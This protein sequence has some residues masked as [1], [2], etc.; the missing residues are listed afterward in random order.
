MARPPER[1]ARIARVRGV[2][3]VSSSGTNYGAEVEELSAGIGR[4]TTMLVNPRRRRRC[5][6]GN[7]RRLSGLEALSSDKVGLSCRLRR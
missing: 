4:T 7:R 1:Q 2:F 5:L 6:A 3:F